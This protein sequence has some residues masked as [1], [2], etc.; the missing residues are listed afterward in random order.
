MS[1][2]FF[3][4]WSS[5]DGTST[6]TAHRLDDGIELISND[7]EAKGRVWFPVTAAPTFAGWLMAPF[8]G[9]GPFERATTGLRA[10]ADA[11]DGIDRELTAALSY[12]LIKHVRQHIENSL[13]VLRMG[14]RPHNVPVNTGSRL[15]L[16][17]GRLERVH[18]WLTG[19]APQLRVHQ[20]DSAIKVI[21]EDGKES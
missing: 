19:I 11:L 4:V 16:A 2:E 21:E 7:E 6:I 8:E 12:E 1:T 15:L 17:L 18:G 14:K 5:D 3:R 9:S 13:A 10:V 20:V